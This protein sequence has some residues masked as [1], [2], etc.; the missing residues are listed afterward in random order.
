MSDDDS[1]H[2]MI[3]YNQGANWQ[4][5]PRPANAPCK[6]ETKVGLEEGDSIFRRVYILR[7]N[8]RCHVL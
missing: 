5:I 3:S 6:D 1:I 7:F 2:T 4:K 8:V